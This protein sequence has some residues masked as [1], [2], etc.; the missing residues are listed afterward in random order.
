MFYFSK[1]AL[2]H[3]KKNKGAN[4]ITNASVNAFIGRPDLLDYTCE[5]LLASCFCSA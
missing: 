2:P 1:A 5:H 4:I 3:L